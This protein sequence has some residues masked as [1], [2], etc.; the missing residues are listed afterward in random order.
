MAFVL[1]AKRFDFSTGG[2]P[3]VVV[4]RNEDGLRFGIRAGDRLVLQSDGRK[5][6]VQADLTHR[7]VRPG[8]I[9]LFRE[10]WKEN[11]IQPQQA[12]EI[13][14]FARPLSIEAVKKKLLGKK[15]N[16]SEFDAVVKDII[17]N[18]FGTT[19][20]TYFV[21][22]SFVRE[23]SNDELYYLTKAIALN[24][25][26]IRFKRKI[27]ADKHSVGGLAGNRTT[28]IV[29]PIIAS[30]GVC[31]PKTSSRAITSPSGTADTMEVLAPVAFPVDR[32]LKIVKKN[33]ACL[34]WGG[35]LQ[36]APADDRIIKVSRPLSLEPYSKMIV[37]IMA[38]KVAMGITHLVVDMPYGDST[39]IPD[40]A[41][42]KRLAAKFRYL[43]RRFNI[44]IRVAMIEA[45]EPI[46]KGVGPALEAR[47]VL[48]VLQQK[49]Y[50]PKDLEEKALK[51]AGM[52]IELIGVARKGTGSSVARD[53]LVSGKAWKA[54]QGI[55]KS[56]GGRPSLDSEDVTLGA[57]RFRVY[58]KHGGVVTRINN[59]A[60]DELA[61]SLGA[62][63]DKVGGLHLKKRLHEK[64]VAGE[65]LYTCYASSQSRLNLAI[66]A[67]KHIHV[68]TITRQ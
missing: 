22:S 42:A 47:D 44:K 25:E 56:Q 6:I 65:A 66:A 53:Q 49:E 43:G 14:P 55:I 58:A 23:Y 18:R 24:G 50:R 63:E 7:R 61:R 60:I 39:K 3:F 19:E 13:S 32:I 33:N 1:R 10:V 52:L 64:V 11:R 67:L 28:M 4:I 15:L 17:N 62:P 57:K 41:S 37:S 20:L 36:L 51:L 30:I 26:Q 27:V 16:Q 21:A 9:G 54:M 34:V 5:I 2:Q 8:E 12:V 46:G 35:G 29:V 40:L 31:I 59:R 38:K 48:R 68:F 45:K